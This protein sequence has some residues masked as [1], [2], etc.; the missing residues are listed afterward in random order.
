MTNIKTPHFEMIDGQPYQVY[1]PSKPEEDHRIM[2]L[3]HG[4]LGNE[5][6][7]WV[8]TNPIPDTYT[9]LAPRAP[10]QTEPNQ[11][12]WHAIT[13]QWPD[14]DTYQSLAD[15]LIKQT[16]DWAEANNRP[17][18]QIDVM[19]FSQGA[20]L[21]LAM[22]ILFPE[23]IGRTAILAGFLPRTWMANLPDV[24]SALT[25]KPFFIAHGTQDEVAPIAK[26][27]RAA[28]WLKEKG[29]EVTFCAAD[30]GH[31]L[32]ANCFNSLGEFFT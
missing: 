6:V 18:E 27:Q 2:L 24:S 19:G 20:V 14:L 8:L 10:V 5:K 30:T 13:P 26:A 23:K 3:L 4:H 15:V 1:S 29:A 31:K 25:K 32:S 28:D 12:S 16:Q 11:Y 7:M 9:M 21:A 17:V 22:G